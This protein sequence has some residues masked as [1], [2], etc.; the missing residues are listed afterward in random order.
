MGRVPAY[1]CIFIFHIFCSSMNHGQGRGKV[2]AW[3]WQECGRKT[4]RWVCGAQWQ[5]VHLRLS[6]YKMLAMPWGMSSLH[7]ALQLTSGELPIPPGHL[8]SC[9]CLKIQIPVSQKCDA[10]DKWGLASV[11]RTIACSISSGPSPNGSTSASSWTLLPFTVFTADMLK[12][13]L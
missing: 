5:H 6:R 2:T 10:E 4:S 8:I 13:V 11:P 1:F 3:K 7:D 9:T 12:S